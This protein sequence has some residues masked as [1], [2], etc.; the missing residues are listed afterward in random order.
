MAQVPVVVYYLINGE[1]E[2]K[3]IHPMQ[4]CGATDVCGS[5]RWTRFALR[6]SGGDLL[7][8]QRMHK[9]LQ[10]YG[11]AVVND[12]RRLCGRVS[13]GYLISAMPD[14][15]L[16]VRGKELVEHPRKVRPFCAALCSLAHTNLSG[17]S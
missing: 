10:E 8:L 4:G 6:T 12:L 16:A 17:N 14:Q 13:F 5:G 1:P 15:L 2:T 9:L 3:Q 7:D 11:Y